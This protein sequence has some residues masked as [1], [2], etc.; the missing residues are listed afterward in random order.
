MRA[1]TQYLATHKGQS[2]TI[3][4]YNGLKLVGNVS[5]ASDLKAHI[6]FAHPYTPRWDCG[7]NENTN[8]FRHQDLPKDRDLTTIASQKIGRTMDKPNQRPRNSLSYRKP[9]KAAFNA[10]TSL[11]VVL[12]SLIHDVYRK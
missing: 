1:I 2:H 12:Q 8:G 9:Y 7:L 6:F 11:T 10:S 5:I 3:T 4:Y